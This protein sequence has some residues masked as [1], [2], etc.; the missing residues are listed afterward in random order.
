MTVPGPGAEAEERAL[1]ALPYEP[2]STTVAYGEH[3]SQVVDFYRPAGAT[4]PREL[5][6]TLLHGGFWREAYD[7][8]HL[9][10]LAAALA[11][12]GVE[13][14]LAEYRRVGGG[15]GLPATFEDV[16]RITALPGA[17]ARHV[18]VGHSA[19]GHL[20][21]WAA[22]A[23][24]GSV[25]EVV[26]VAPVADLRRARA[27]GLGNG[28]VTALLG[29]GEHPEADPSR[30]SPPRMPVTVLHGTADPDVP[31][32]VSGGYVSAMRGCGGGVVLR[33]LRGVGHFGAVTPGVSACGE[34]LGVL[35][36]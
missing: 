6:V 28:A 11:G 17:P 20:A 22:S 35:G 25:T 5:R 24:P 7:R 1:M 31:L 33:A 32:S 26:A 23:A 16:A 2:P 12:P 36:L 9:A 4:G 30:L 18:L 15:G 21:L 3:P 29:P 19:G 34:L 14:A 13:V 27:L 10:P 8:R